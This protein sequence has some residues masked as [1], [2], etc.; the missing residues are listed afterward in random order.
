MKAGICIVCNHQVGNCEADAWSSFIRNN[1]SISE[2]Y[3]FISMKCN[4]W[5][6][7]WFLVKPFISNM[8]LECGRCDCK[9]VWTIERCM[10]YA[11]CVVC[12]S[13]RFIRI[14]FNGKSSDFTALQQM[15]HNSFGKFHWSWKNENQCSIT[16]FKI[17]SESDYA[18]RQIQFINIILKQIHAQNSD[19][20]KFEAPIPWKWT[21]KLI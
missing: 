19:S 5:Y 14:H 13:A 6:G 16:D 15:F 3:C 1:C 8:K 20:I 17:A 2:Q 21:R 12:R 9:S 4:E 18:S 11:L 10:R 7:K